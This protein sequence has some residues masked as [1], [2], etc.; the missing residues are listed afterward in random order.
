MTAASTIGTSVSASYS[1]VKGFTI[2]LRPVHSMTLQCF[3]TTTMF[4]CESSSVLELGSL[5][6][7]SDPSLLTAAIKAEWIRREVCVFGCR[8]G[9]QH[10]FASGFGDA[11]PPSSNEWESVAI[12]GVCQLVF[13][14]TFRKI[15]L[16]VTFLVVG[17]V[18]EAVV[19]VVGAGFLDSDIKPIM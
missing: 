12:A 14:L 1:G 19:A 17:V 15:E 2:A 4:A 16:S 8:P 7:L 9:S 18:T 10:L 5:I 11:S 6:L 3:P 13:C